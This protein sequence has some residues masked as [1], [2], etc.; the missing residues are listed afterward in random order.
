MAGW[1]LERPPL[2]VSAHA[3][4][5]DRRR[6]S[7]GFDSIRESALR[8]F[9]AAAMSQSTLASVWERIRQPERCGPE[10]GYASNVRV[11]DVRQI[12]Q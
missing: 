9:V 3:S 2:P 11:H 10:S 8:L 6:S 12:C 4:P 7:S 5:L 1:Q